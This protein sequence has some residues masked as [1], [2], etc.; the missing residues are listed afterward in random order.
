MSIRAQRILVWWAVAFILIYG[1]S[2]GFLI[3]L[4]PLP[5]ATLGASEV[6]AFYREN[7]LQIRLG[8]M[9]CGWVGAFMVPLAVV[10]G[11]QMARLEKGVPVWSILEICGGCL[12]SL[13]LVLP[14]IF[15]GVAAFTPDRPQEI[16]LLMHELAN[17]VLVTTD[18][19]FIFQNVA[20]G[21]VSLTHGADRRSPFPRW[22]GYFTIWAAFM[23]E[24]G[25]LGF[26][27]RTGPFAWNGLFVYWT[28]LV[29]FGAWFF[30]MAYMLLRALH[31]Q[32]LVET[33]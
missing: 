12:M 33:Q 26:L 9:I 20:I 19:F 23:F 10:I 7:S 24:A 21:Y 6:A 32:A 15:W 29:V 4:L 22:M 31:R 25:A 28:P 16:T 17:L 11:V 8:A 14:P 30:I 3:Q 1:L 2:Y 18:Q 27:P 13:F 5:S